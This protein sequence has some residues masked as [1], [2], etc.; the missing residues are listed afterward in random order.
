MAGLNLTGCR[1]AHMSMRSPSLPKR[2]NSWFGFG[3]LLC[4]L[5][6]LPEWAH[7]ILFF[8]CLLMVPLRKRSC[9]LHL[10]SPD[11]RHVLVGSGN[12]CLSARQL[13]RLAVLCARVLLGSLE[14]VPAVLTP[15]GAHLVLRRSMLTGCLWTRTNYPL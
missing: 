4:Y 13:S 11:Y 2:G 10:A 7:L 15:G 3:G 8:V 1:R 9:P 12:Y 14:Q 6:K 5:Y